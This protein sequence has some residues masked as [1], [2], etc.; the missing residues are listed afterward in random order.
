MTNV[1]FQALISILIYLLVLVLTWWALQSLKI[2]LLFHK[3]QSGRSRVMMLLLAVA[4]SY[5]VA[6]Y[7]LDYVNWSLMLPQ[8]YGG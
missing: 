7:I 6:R 1:G 8:I 5:P 3:P 4:V 2:D